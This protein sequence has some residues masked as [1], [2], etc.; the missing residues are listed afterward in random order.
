MR[1]TFWLALIV[2][3]ALAVLVVLW[4]MDAAHRKGREQLERATDRIREESAAEQR[5]IRDHF[6][7]E[8]TE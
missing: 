3:F 7:G 6:G 8:E 2:S 5:A 4:L 1:T